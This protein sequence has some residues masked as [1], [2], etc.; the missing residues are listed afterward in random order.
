VGPGTFIHELI[1]IGGGVNVFAD[2]NDLYAPVSPE[3]IIARGADVYLTL[4]GNQLD[5]RLVGR[6]PVRE[7]GH[8]VQLP[9]P[10]LGAA[11]REVARA[12]HPAALP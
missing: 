6:I 4:H 12:L 8:G 11:A 2:L 7:L 1:R 10:D 9:G 5:A 3:Q